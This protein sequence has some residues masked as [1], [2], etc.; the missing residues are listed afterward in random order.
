MKTINLLI[1]IILSFS[2]KLSSQSLH[3]GCASREFSE[4]KMKKLP[5]YGNNEFLDQVLNNVNYKKDS[6]QI[7]YRIPITL[8]AFTPKSD[9]QT[10]RKL[11]NQLNFYNKENNT[12]FEFY[13]A[14]IIPKYKSTPF[15]IGYT[16][17]AFFKGFFYREK[18]T[19]NIMLVDQLIRKS[20]F[21]PTR[22]YRG[23]YSSL[24]HNI[25][26]RLNSSSTSMTHE[27][28]HFFGLHHPHR[29]WKRSKRH[30]ES[31]SRERKAKR[32]FKNAKNC[33]L[34][35]DA[36]CDTPA[37][38]VLSKYVS[39]DCEYTGNLTDKWGD[40]YVPNTKNIMSYPTFINCRDNFTE[41]QKAV[42]LYTAKKKNIPE[43]S[44]TD[45][46]FQT[47]E[48]EPNNS[49]TTASLLKNKTLK[50]TLHLKYAGKKKG[51]IDNDEDWFLIEKDSLNADFNKFNLKIEIENA[52][53]IDFVAEVNNFPAVQKGKIIKIKQKTSLI[54]I[55]FSKNKTFYIKIT[56]AKANNININY[57]LEL[58]KWE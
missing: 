56:K 4:R 8:W 43:W 13:Y 10:Y 19:L 26:L 21:K 57:S 5:W 46:R 34:N 47:D 11:I 49:F 28:G 24:T 38:P 16:L 37:E 52:S 44:A 15:K 20:L 1:L 54:P 17:P 40:K 53:K 22:Y 51:I 36:I 32:L 27:I 31:V 58:I 30:Q 12:G 23:Q 2:I 41:G 7:F 14:Q 18:E 9:E 55:D 33:E 29:G 3:D 25:I 35:G 48:Y 39:K 50:N 42:M 45:K 6:G